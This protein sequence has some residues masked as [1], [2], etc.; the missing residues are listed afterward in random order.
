MDPGHLRQ[1]RTPHAAGNEDVFRLNA[2]LVGVYGV[3]TAVL[4]LNPRNLHV[5]VNAQG[6]ALHRVFT[7]Q[8][9]S[10]K[11]VNHPGGGAVETA[12]NPVGVDKRGQLLDAF[13]G[14]HF[15]G[16]P[17]RLGRSDAAGDF[18]HPLRRAGQLNAA[19]LDKGAKFGVGV[20]AV[21]REMGHLF[22][23]V[24]GENKVRG[25][26]G[27]AAGVGERPFVQNDHLLPA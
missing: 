26:A 17:P 19:G 3:G 14:N 8:R 15:P 10:A 11:R 23:M 21:P 6:I 9:A 1:Q 22:G 16:F 27:G 5:G 24:N 18:L 20:D 7:H 12:Q 25:V 13:R 4:Y 2:A